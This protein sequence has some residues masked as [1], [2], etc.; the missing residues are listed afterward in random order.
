MTRKTLL[1]TISDRAEQNFDSAKLVQARKSPIDP[2]LWKEWETCW[3]DQAKKFMEELRA[4]G[5]M[6]TADTLDKTLK[7]LDWKKEYYNDAVQA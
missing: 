3:W 2:V 5:L 6:V 7:G 1:G 4:E